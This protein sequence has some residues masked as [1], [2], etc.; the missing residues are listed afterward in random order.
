MR[1]SN[2]SEGRSGGGGLRRSP[3]PRRAQTRTVWPRLAAL[4]TPLPLQRPLLLRMLGV[5]LMLLRVWAVKAPLL[6]RAI[7][8][9]QDVA[10]YV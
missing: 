8:P 9:L 2:S 4:L 1:W 10:H 3:R 5:L 7:L 6:A